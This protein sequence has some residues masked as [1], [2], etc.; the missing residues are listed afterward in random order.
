MMMMTG[1]LVKGLY[2]NAMRVRQMKATQA[3][4]I[5][6]SVASLLPFGGC[7]LINMLWMDHKKTC[8][9]NLQ[10]FAIFIFGREVL[11]S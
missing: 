1:V 6:Y 4:Y 11:P 8:T 3:S 5:W 10:L 2:R 9:L 7:T